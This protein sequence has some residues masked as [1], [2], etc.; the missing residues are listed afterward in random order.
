MIHDVCP[1]V[2]ETIK[3][4]FTAFTYRGDTLCG[5]AA[6]KQHAAFGF[7]KAKIMD[8]P[9]KILGEAQEQAMGNFGRI[10]SLKDLPSD[11]VLT[12]YIKQAM[13]HNEQKIKVP[14]EIR[15]KK[16]VELVVPDYFIKAL[17]KNKAAK[18]TFEN[19]SPSCKREYI[20]WITEAKQETT[21]A[22]RLKQ[23]LEWMSEGKQR[24]WKYMVK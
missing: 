11:K 24:N 17:S 4:S 13:Y 2:E 6:F 14:R 22:R 23:A 8:D 15:V 1:E 20:E 10:T 7:W 16:K 9:H 19:F 21:R 5:M 18:N 3:W 12:D